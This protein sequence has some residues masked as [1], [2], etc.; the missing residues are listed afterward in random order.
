VNQLKLYAA[1]YFQ[2][3]G[4][5]PITIQIVPVAGAKLEVPFTH[6]ECSKLLDEAAFTLKSL[7]SIISAGGSSIYEVLGTPTPQNCQ[8]CS[9]AYLT[10]DSDFHNF[11]Y[12]KSS[13]VYLLSSAP[14]LHLVPRSL[15]LFPASR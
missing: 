2:M 4:I 7:N 15:G 14:A 5:W 9:F 8:F 1:L 13:F 11:S 10:Q 3:Y 6:E 12:E